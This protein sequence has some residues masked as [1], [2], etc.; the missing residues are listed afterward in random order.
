MQDC[1]FFNTIRD[2]F[3]LDDFKGRYTIYLLC[4]SG[5]VKFYHEGQM[6]KAIGGDLV[7]WRRT[8]SCSGISIT[9]GTDADIL[10]VSD[11]FLELHRP[12]TEW[13]AVGYGYLE[14]HPVLHP[15]NAFFFDELDILKSD[16]EQIG[17]YVAY[18][19][20]YLGEEI[21]GLQL[22]VLLY[23]IWRVFFRMVFN[24]EDGNNLPSY[25]FAD[26]LL[27]VKK[28]CKEHR[29]VAWYA[30]L[31]EI[32]P[33]YLTEVSI[34]ATMRPAGD[35]IDI[36]SARLLRKELS[37]Q[38]VS[39]TALSKEMNFSSLPAFTRYVKRVLGC[40]PSEFRESLK[41]Q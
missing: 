25:H 7:V 20:D 27:D 32:T 13:D 40:T 30:Q 1:L 10:L 33:K 28:Y 6:F 39:L 24:A 3:D 8:K 36:Y 22:R 12:E 37:S 5:D 26:F 17:R 18:F 34:A 29:D 4:K 23:D 31:R 21:T 16:F 9:A 11:D 38:D 14:N 15:V 2:T 41:T 19:D 35:W